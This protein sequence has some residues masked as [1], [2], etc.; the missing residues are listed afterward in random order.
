MNR[1]A[2]KFRVLGSL[3][4]LL[5]LAALFAPL[6]E[7]IQE[8]YAT[9]TWTQM[10]YIRSA[11]AEYLP[12][13]KTEGMIPGQEGW[14]FLFMALPLV[15]SAAAGIW[16]LAGSHTQK[17]SSLLIFAALA[18]YI[19][20]AAGAPQLW[21]EAAKGQSYC[22]GLACTL[23]LVFTGTGTVF[24]ALA[25]AASPRKRK[26]TAESIPQM[27]E[28]KQQQ[29][30]AKYNIMTGEKQEKTEMPA[31]GVLVGITGVYAGA[32]IPMT[33]GEYLLLGR[34]PNNHLVFGGQANVSRNHC[35]IQWDAGRQKYIFRDYS[36]NGSFLHGSED[37]LPQNLDLELEPG[38]TI[39]IGDAGNAFFL[40]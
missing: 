25:L 2:K 5:N 31:H 7:R 17:G 36:S 27:E 13:E 9:V 8:N 24:A 20:M 26:V 33:D 21:P 23:P 11:L 32:E 28:V 10:D 1:F 18:L 6:T 3:C 37:C 30:E 16:G 40:K 38:T 4:V 29:V 34:Q 12:F 39:D 14:I 22:R 19:G 15:L 35:R